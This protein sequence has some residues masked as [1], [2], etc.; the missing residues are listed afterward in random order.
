MRWRFQVHETIEG[1]GHAN[2]MWKTLCIVFDSEA[3]GLMQRL[4]DQVGWTYRIQEEN[5]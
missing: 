5:Q 1:G 3:L 2:E 4:L